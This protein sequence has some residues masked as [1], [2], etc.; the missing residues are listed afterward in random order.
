VNIFGGFTPMKWESASHYKYKVDN[1]S[2]SFIFAR[3]NPHNIPV[4]RFVLMT[5]HKHLAISDTAK[6]DPSFGV[7]IGVSD[8]CNANTTS[9]TWHGCTYIDGI[10]VG[11][12]IFLT[13]PNWTYRHTL[14]AKD[15]KVFE[16]TAYAT[17][18]TDDPPLRL[19]HSE[20][21]G[22]AVFVASFIFQ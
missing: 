21:G 15:I 18:N 11:R 3:K 19:Q 8:H 4:G 10:K 9:G 6:C 14:Q 16:I 2:K 13:S 17:D 22:E 1:S 7:G 5:E 12:C 20:K